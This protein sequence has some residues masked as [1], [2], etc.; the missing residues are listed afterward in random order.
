MILQIESRELANG[1]TS[2][3]LA[4]RICMGRDCQEIE[5]KVGDLLKAQRKKLIFDMSKVTLMDSAGV[6]IL[7]T[8]FGRLKRAGGEL[9]L[10][11]VGGSVKDILAMTLLDTVLPIFPSTED[12]TRNF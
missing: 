5:W 6:G 1:V 4:G 8:C 11:G 3:S 10:A 9:R 12:A 7:A 2:L